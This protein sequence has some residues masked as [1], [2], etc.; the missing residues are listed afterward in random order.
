LIGGNNSLKIIW[1]KYEGK[2]E[3]GGRDFYS[4]GI[5]RFVNDL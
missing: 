2:N 5:G 3:K 4:C 1:D